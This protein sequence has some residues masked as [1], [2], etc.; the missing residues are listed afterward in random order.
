MN[1]KKILIFFAIALL[2]GFSALSLQQFWGS[3][4]GK[5]MNIEE[6]VSVPV[7]HFTSGE[8]VRVLPDF[9]VAAEK[10]LNA[11]V[12]VK[13]TYTQHTMQ[14]P[15]MYDFFFGSPFNG[16]GNPMPRMGSGSGVIIGEDGYIVTNNHVIEDAENI[17]VVLN[18]NRSYK[19]KL[20]GRDPATDIALLKIKETKLPIVT[21]GN[22]DA[23][24]I[25]EWVLAVGNPFNLTS[26]VTAGIVSAKE[27]NINLLRSKQGNY[28]IESFIQTD[29]AVNPG[30]SGGALVNTSGYLVGINTAIASRTGSYSGYSF[31]VPSTIVKKVVADLK[32]FG[33]VQR[34]LLGVNIQPVD[35]EL[36]QELNLEKPTGVYVAKVQANSAAA[37]AGIKE[38]DVIIKVNNNKVE[39]VSELQEQISRF[40][41]GDRIQITVMRDNDVKRYMV[42]LKNSMGTT[43][44]INKSMN[45][46]LGASFSEV[47]KEILK[48]ME[49]KEGVQV[50][51]LERG[52][53]LGAG[54]REG[55]IITH[56]NRK[57]VNNPQELEKILKDT[58]G[59]VYLEGIYPTGEVA[60]YAF[61]LE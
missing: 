54:V 55:F 59:G 38:K 15:S 56:V 39:K 43:D 20:I 57:S 24:K 49:I 4:S 58:H 7:N 51:D 37:D 50:V 46:V 36:A 30:N 32:E 34:A 53:L 26:T 2:G 60:Y 19:A 33:T 12:H 28:A 10:T 5:V 14:Q 3:R 40:S 41:P 35:A 29:A 8:S 21:F 18:D 1:T 61:G 11:V 48:K 23:L 13:T 22:S 27:R 47:P 17:E 31:A 45:D 44:V 9:T 6:P 52:K 42:T 16:G 25:G